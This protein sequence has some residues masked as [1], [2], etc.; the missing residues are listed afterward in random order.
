MEL[1]LR[2]EQQLIVE[3]EGN[4]IVTAGAG[5]GKT[6]TL[7]RKVIYDIERSSDYRRVAAITFTLKAAQQIKDRLPKEA[8]GHFISTNNQF[9]M[10]EIIPFFEDAYGIAPK[11]ELQPDYVTKLNTW[12]ELFALVCETGRVAK[13]A[14]QKKNFI[15]ELATQIIRSS[16]ACRLFLQ[17]KYFKIFVDEYQ[18]CDIDMHNFFMCLCKELSIT[19][20]LVG[21]LKQFIYGW[22]GAQ[23]ESF[24]RLLQDDDFAKYRLDENFRC[25]QQIQN[26]ANL[27]YPNEMSHLYKACELNGEVM[28][29]N[30]CAANMYPDVI[31]A[32]NSDTRFAVLRRSNAAAQRS[33]EQLAMHSCQCQYIKTPAVSEIYT[34]DGWLYYELARYYI[35]PE[36]SEY[37]IMRM[38][39]EELQDERTADALRALL[40]TVPKN[41]PLEADLRLVAIKTL[42]LF[43]YTPS[44]KNIQLFIADVLNHEMH[45]AFH[46]EDCSSVAMTIHSAKGA[47]FDQV[48]LFGDDF[49]SW[50]MED[51]DLLYVAATRAK[52][53]LIIVTTD[54][55][56]AFGYG[57]CNLLKKSNHHWPEV[58]SLLHPTP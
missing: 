5:A 29:A 7:V 33:A 42:S 38:A 8:T 11:G 23:R 21:D 35:L 27:L 55:P 36:L 24:E 46:P 3:A 50:T 22:K 54:T 1:E 49:K 17:A 44:D 16:E 28:V 53:R 48:I 47:A 6:L 32:L 4:V 15:F 56:S 2:P 52:K 51:I 30:T 25:C 45:P 43:G 39:P 57:Y 41:S 40:E 19:H 31:Q 10:R 12:D 58:F 9:A 18:D 26:F 20:F 34:K 14:N 37:D 13:Y